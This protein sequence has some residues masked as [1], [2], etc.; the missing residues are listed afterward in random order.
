MVR[1]ERGIRPEEVRQQ[2]RHVLFVE[3]KDRNSVDPQVLNELFGED[4]I[5]IEPLGPSYS[6]KSV[7]QALYSYHPSY[8]FLIDRDHHRDDFIEQCWANFPDPDKHNLLIWKK[9]EIENYFL[10]PGYLFQS[11]Y[12]EVSQEEIERKILQFVEDRLFM[13]AANYVVTSIRE[14]LKKNWIEKFSNLDEFS[15]KDAALEK[16]KG[17]SEFKT[18]RTDVC[19]IISPDELEN[20]F[21]HIVDQML[22]DADKPVFGEG[23]WID[24]IQGKKVLTQVIHSGCFKVQATDGSNL[25]GKDKLNAVVKD[26]LKKETEV[27]PH[28]FTVLKEL[29]SSRVNG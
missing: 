1:L 5:K 17:A 8:Y 26:L 19:K 20:R 2:S 3:G 14:E 29:I 23:K 12:R 22:G 10:E 9:R 28:D 27:Q 13:D 16:L 24:M 4:H 6:V 11:K 15:S 21:N 25:S 18:H 7:A